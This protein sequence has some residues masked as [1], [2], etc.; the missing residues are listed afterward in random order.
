[1]ECLPNISDEHCPLG[2]DV[3]TREMRYEFKDASLEK[4]VDSDVMGPRVV[5]KYR[6]GA[7]EG[8][9]FMILWTYIHSKL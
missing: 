2:E 6:K 8:G 7:K 1:M 9:Y 4:W 3:S 5:R